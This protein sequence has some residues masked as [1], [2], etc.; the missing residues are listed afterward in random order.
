[1]A[2]EPIKDTIEKINLQLGADLSC[3]KNYN[4]VPTDNYEINIATNL[5]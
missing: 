1:M 3:N 5:E 4:S 2:K